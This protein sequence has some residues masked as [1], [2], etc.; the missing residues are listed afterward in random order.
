MSIDST[1]E[2]TDAALASRLA[3]D[4]GR[5]LLEIRD[6]VG[7][8]DGAA[9]RDAGDAGSQKL[10][11]AA[12][13]HYRPADAVL[14]EEA[15]DDRARLTA[16]RV[17]IIDPLDGTREFSE[18]GRTDWAVHV[19]LWQGGALAVG[20]VA[21]PALGVTLSSDTITPPAPAEAGPPRLVASRTRAPR[22]VTDVAERIG[23]VVVPM[24][25]AGAK[26]AAVIRGEADV[27]LHAGGQY[28]WDSAAP[29]AVALAAGL[30]ATRIDGS[31]LRYNQPD[32]LLPDLLICR[33]GLADAVLAAIG[34]SAAG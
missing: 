11:A 22:L 23:G 15:V 20:A 34:E 30:H 25:S 18:T 1:T 33:P 3:T 31:P 24:G 26:A 8:A 7:F 14:S 2:L 19:A 5:R 29:V 13:A 6:E 10:L 9:L 32:P 16:D 12:L 28:E 21:L 27:Y 17:W 4:A